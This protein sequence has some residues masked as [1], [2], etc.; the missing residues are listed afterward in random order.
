MQDSPLLLAPEDAAKRLSIGR[1]KM[2]ELI[3][4]G[5]IQSVK[6]GRAR[7]VPATALT[8]YVNRLAAAE[9]A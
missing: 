7:R 9:V 1:T 2:F 8:E 4:S 6:I 5:E 3:A